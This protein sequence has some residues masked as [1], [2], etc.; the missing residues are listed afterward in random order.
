MKK[1]QK[2]ELEQLRKMEELKNEYLFISES[3]E[4]RKR[5]RVNEVIKELGY[6]LE[7]SYNI[8]LEDGS[9]KEIKEEKKEK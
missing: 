7:K 3:I 4:I 9:V 8:N 5:L 1:I 6:D 2:K